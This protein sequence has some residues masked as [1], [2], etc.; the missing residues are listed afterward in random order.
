MSIRVIVAACL[1]VCC[2]GAPEEVASLGD[3]AGV[4]RQENCIGAQASPVPPM[5]KL[6]SREAV[7][8]MI[9]HV[10]T[11]RAHKHCGHEETQTSHMR[12][13]KMTSQLVSFIQ[14][15]TGADKALIDHHMLKGLERHVLRNLKSKSCK[16][17]NKFRN[18]MCATNGH[19]LVI[20]HHIHMKGAAAAKAYIRAYFVRRRR[21]PE[22]LAAKHKE[23]LNKHGG[24]KRGG[25]TNHA[26]AK[27]HLDHC[28]AKMKGM[29][30]HAHHMAYKMKQMAV[31]HAAAMKKANAK[32]A[33]CPPSKKKIAKKLAAKVVN[34]KIQKAKARL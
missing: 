31:A 21:T 25:H 2:L 13:E 3:G 14:E 18:M 33:A 11:A 30:A 5:M 17:L 19:A 26:C 7:N 9:R 6:F 20:P 10:K 24:C 22:L 16:A 8:V 34:K 4:A 1:V 12:S 32:A 15:K 23:T 27:Y 29:T 28:A